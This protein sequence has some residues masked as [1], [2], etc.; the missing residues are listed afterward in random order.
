MLEW[1]R[2]NTA[3][4]EFCAD[5]VTILFVVAVVV[6]GGGGA[7]VVTVVDDVVVVVN[8][9]VVVIVIVSSTHTWVRTSQRE[10]S[11]WTSPQSLL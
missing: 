8:V 7:V 5:K 2:R 4:G 9:I 1:V 6:V 11:A 3:D 10:S